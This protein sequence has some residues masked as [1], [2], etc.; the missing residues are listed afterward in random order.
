MM[1]SSVVGRI[2]VCVICAAVSLEI[3]SAQAAK[4]AIRFTPDDPIAVDDDTVQD[5]SGFKEVEL[6]EAY[7]LLSNQ[8]GSPGDRTPMRALNVNTIDE[9]P[10]SSWFVNRIGAR[11]MSIS[12][13]VRGANTFDPTEARE[14]D[15][16]TIVNGKG[17]GGYQPGFRAERPGDPG[18][19]YQLE[20]DPRD[21]PRLATGAEFIGALIY[22]ALGYHVQDF[23]VIKVDPRNITIS[24][25]AKIRD[26]SGERKFTRHDLQNILRVAAKDA[27]GR[28]YMSA[29][30]YAGEDLGNF[31]YHGTRSDDP[32]DVFPHEHRRELRANRVFAAWLA[33][34]DSRALNTRNLRIKADGRTYIR[35]YMHDF[36][37]IMGSSTRAPE[38][39][40]SNHEYY[41]EKDLSLK[42]LWTLGL[43]T[44]P[45]YR[46]KGPDR[47]SLPPSAGYFE[48][49]SFVPDEWRPNY[50][51]TA[52]SNMQPDDAFWGA[53]LVS[54]FSDAM[55]RAIVQAAGYDDPQAVDYLASTLIRR[56]DIVA[57]HWLNGVNPI[58]DLSLSPTG[59][60]TF[61]NAAVAARVA[62]H[63]TYTIAWA[64][65]DNESGTS[66][67]ISVEKQQEP[68]G[69]AP[70][71]LLSKANYIE[72]TI[73]STHP[74]RPGWAA[75]VRTYFRREG[76]GWKTVGIVR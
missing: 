59:A 40:T 62:T 14:W 11:P 68:K 38:P 74:E 1:R 3:I 69:T 76:A 44:E 36:G 54:R 19:M 51:N 41:V 52:F 66:E 9:V 42:R 61:V 45:A 29:A 56:R 20:V 28:V 21:H 13:V 65:Y 37:A 12:E 67:R 2:V 49:D 16:W 23:Y 30:R 71:V 55:I 31:E 72:A 15:R 60:L 33:H 35:H 64:S 22:H 70:A 73:W 43:V 17:P 34:D 47:D 46:I 53:R 50:P 58:V 27:D 4:R 26:A 10:D 48:S 25:K 5:A 6:S 39:S 32:N 24:E 57:R 8:F 63:G 18:Q 7:D 75:P